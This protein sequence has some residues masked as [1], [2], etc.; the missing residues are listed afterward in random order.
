MAAPSA[1]NTD[2]AAAATPGSAVPGSRRIARVNGETSPVGG[3]AWEY[4][5]APETTKVT[6]APRY[7]LF[8]NGRFIEPAGKGGAGR[9]IANRSKKTSETAARDVPAPAY[10]STINPA[11]ETM[12]CEVAQA[13][14]ADVDAA[15]RAATAALPK[16]AALKPTERAKYLFPHRTSDSG[17]G[18]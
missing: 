15:V 9:A 1:T 2:S 11:N 7:N 13:G 14:A 17:A 6:I 4:S 16:W 12:L 8:I 5:P 18:A 10:F 3:S